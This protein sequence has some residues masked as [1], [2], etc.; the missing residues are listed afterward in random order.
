MQ[1]RASSPFLEGT[2]S[3]HA[4]ECTYISTTVSVDRRQFQ[5]CIRVKKLLVYDSCI[6]Y[7]LLLYFSNGI[8]GVRFIWIMGR[9]R[10]WTCIITYR[11]FRLQILHFLKEVRR[12][13]EADVR[14]FVVVV[15]VGGGRTR[16]SS[17][18]S[19]LAL[20]LTFPAV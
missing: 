11:P 4:R 10:A 7:V 1:E 13:A 19:P 17:I 3:G 12:R 5:V 2:P 14:C 16:K 15:L 6:A 20:S 9:L 18:I 8:L